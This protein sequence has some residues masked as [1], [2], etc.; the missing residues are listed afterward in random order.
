MKNIS[1]SIKKV[2]LYG[3]V[4]TV[5]FPFVLLIL[6]SCENG[7]AKEKL[8]NKIVAQVRN[9]TPVIKQKTTIDS[10]ISSAVN[11]LKMNGL[12]GSE[13]NASSCIS[14]AEERKGDFRFCL[15]KTNYS[16]E[17]GEEYEDEPLYI[18]LYVRNNT[19]LINYCVLAAINEED[20]QFKFFKEEVPVYT[21]YDAATGWEKL[22]IYNAD[23]NA[24]MIT[25]AYD[26]SVE[27]KIDSMNL[28]SGIF[29]SGKHSH[30]LFSVSNNAGN[31]SI[32]HSAKQ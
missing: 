24:F 28:K 14:Y 3:R 31:D 15:L 10:I 30:Q 6:S 16:K 32:I 29:Y 13:T 17:L 5:I 4:L 18:F 25:K 20:F 19:R 1:Q 8:P 26:E 11:F 27:F 9:G 23:E 2:S 12:I 7:T 21:Y 22:L